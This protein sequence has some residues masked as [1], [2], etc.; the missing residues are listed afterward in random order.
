MTPMDDVDSGLPSS[1]PN[2]DQEF[3][4]DGFDFST[5][6]S[7]CRELATDSDEED[8]HGKTQDSKLTKA[9]NEHELTDALMTILQV[10]GSEERPGH[11]GMNK[12][13]RA[14]TLD[15]IEDT[16]SPSYDHDQTAFN[17]LLAAMTSPTE[18]KSFFNQQ[19]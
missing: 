14:M 1:S 3:I 9:A 10:S 17:K 15:E 7:I 5:G 8:N 4:L 19:V 12:P 18:Q 16:Q 2:D 11:P 6:V 13:L